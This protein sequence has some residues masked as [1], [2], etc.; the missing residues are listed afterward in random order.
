M[1]VYWNG[2]CGER[3]PAWCQRVVQD[4]QTKVFCA[5]VY[6][7]DKPYRF[8]KK[9]FKPNV[10]PLLIYECHIGMGQDAEKVGTYDEFRVNVLPRVAAD[11]YNCI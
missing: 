11:G 7:P 6:E 8:K 10:N 9:N 5:Q 2:G 1:K 4:E 3:I